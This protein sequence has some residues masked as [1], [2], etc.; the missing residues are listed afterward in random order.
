MAPATLDMLVRRHVGL[1]YW[2]GDC[3]HRVILKAAVMSAV[4]GANFRSPLRRTRSSARGAAGSGRKCSRIG[5]RRGLLRGTYHDREIG[6]DYSEEVSFRT[7]L[8]Q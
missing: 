1:F 6:N 7:D 2:C 8:R 3:G 5:R 4:L